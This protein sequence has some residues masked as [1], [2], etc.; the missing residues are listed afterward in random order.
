M[1]VLLKLYLQHFFQIVEKQG[2]IFTDN[3]LN[4]W[5]RL[6]SG[7]RM[8]KMPSAFYRNFVPE[9]QQLSPLTLN[10]YS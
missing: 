9:F 1:A 7:K 6:L 8:T 10:F 2:D 3:F 5:P 4:I